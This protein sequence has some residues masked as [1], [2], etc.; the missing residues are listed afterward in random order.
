[1]GD[2]INLRMARKAK[3]RVSATQAADASRAVH[4][5]TKAEKARIADEKARLDRLLNS[6]RLED[7]DR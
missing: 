6:A 3:A 4:G 7:S 2:V 5:R 1:M